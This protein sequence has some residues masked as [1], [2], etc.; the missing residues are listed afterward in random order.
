M[1]R[2]T[3]PFVEHLEEL[4]SRVI[5][6]AAAILVGSIAGFLA[7]D[8]LL[9][10]LAGP[11][12][13]VAGTDSL[14]F[15]R[16]TEGFSV[17]MRVALFGGVILAVPIVL[18]QLWRFV[19]PA[20]TRREKRLVVPLV[21]VL[22]T[23]FAAGIVLGYWSLERGLSFLLGCGGDRLDPLISAEAYLSFAMRFILA[24]GVAFEFPVFLFAAV[25]AGI[26]RRETLRRGRRWAVLIIV[27]LAAVITP[28]GDP[29][30]LL[31][32]SAPLYL[33]YEATLLATR[34]L[35]R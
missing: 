27:V 35:R 32:L 4:R 9:D 1:T 33:L 34:P 29:L 15:F 21:L 10:V 2:A 17:Y 23:L 14:V 8:W 28:S 18:Y 25:A 11:Y 16:P 20:L 3:M 24:F 19:A 5:K 31:L 22:S 26:V 7:A 30:T 12:E 13:D 6:A